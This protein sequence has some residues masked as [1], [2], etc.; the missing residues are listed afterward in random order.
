MLVLNAQQCIMAESCS[1]I[2]VDT[3]IKRA[4]AAVA[5]EIISRF[6]KQKVLVLCGPGNNGKDGYVV[7]NLLQSE[8]W[9]VKVM[10][11]SSTVDGC[12]VISEENLKQDDS[13]LIVDAIFGT[14]LTRPIYG[15]LLNAINYINN[16]NKTVVSIDIPSGINSDTGEIMG[17]AL[18]SHLT[19]TFSYLKLGHVISPG[20]Y[21]SGEVY[22]ADI[23][24]KYNESTV[25]HNSPLLWRE[26][27]PKFNYQSNKYSRGYAV[28]CSVGN[29][30]VG[31]SKLAATSALRAGAGVVTI[32]CDKNAMSIYASSLT[33]IMYKLYDDVI[34]DH[35]ITAVLIGPGCGISECVKERTI[36]ALSKKNCIIDADSISVFYGSHEIL[37]SYIKNNVIMT[38]HEG[39]FKRIF[40]YLTGSALERAKKASLI[41]KAVIVLKGHDTII[42]SPDGRVSINNSS[43]STLA[44]MGS[45]DV[46]SG[47][48]TGFVSCGMDPFF[49]ACCGVWVHSECGKKYT[50]G[51]IADDIVMQIPVV[52]SAFY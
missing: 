10:H 31:A 37:F 45:G 36:K 35:R 4:G 30:S 8:G 15:S 6:L 40:P 43:Y 27:L 12:D 52:L 22:I 41:S 21:C 29:K 13:L 18:V 51:L 46:L 17:I 33:A 19:V 1:G 34:D 11:Y 42:A 49:A 39:E 7:A 26:H 23:G 50:Y 5:K 44:T 32:A 28:V 16:S 3:L 24:L 14:G 2:C 20:R 9:H 48:I 47:I 25:Y 38:P